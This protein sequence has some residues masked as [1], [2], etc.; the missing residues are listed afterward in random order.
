MDRDVS[1]ILA[2]AEPIAAE[3][4]LEVLDVEV[5]GSLVRVLLDSPDEDR[6]V[7]VEDCQAVSH[8]LG[9][10]LEAHEVLGGRYMLEVSSPGVNRLLKKIEHFRRV[11]G[12]KV[13]VRAR[14]GGADRR[15]WLGRLEEV[16]DD[17]I[18]VAVDGGE[19]VRVGWSEIEKANLEFEFEQKPA[20]A[21]RPASKGPSAKT[22][23]SPANKKRR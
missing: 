22:G 15:T 8:R 23:R 12:R 19:E 17:G 11:L 18:R 20:R 7:S 14:P 1:R 13:R 4:G 9:D 5:A 21:G 6:K 10:G 16:G 2:I 3:R